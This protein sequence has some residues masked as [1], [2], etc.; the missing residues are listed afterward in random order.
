MPRKSYARIAI[1][2]RKQEAEI[3]ERKR[4]NARERQRKFYA[5]RREA[6]ALMAEHDVIEVTPA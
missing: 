3:A 1:E 2:R 4:A 6:M 5:K